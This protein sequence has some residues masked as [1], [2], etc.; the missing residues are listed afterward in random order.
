MEGETKNKNVLFISSENSCI[1]WDNNKAKIY[2]LDKNKIINNI[3]YRQSKQLGL[4]K[5]VKSSNEKFQE[6]IILKN[7]QN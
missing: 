2:N 1:N 4:K 7:A 5:I 6:V 3:S